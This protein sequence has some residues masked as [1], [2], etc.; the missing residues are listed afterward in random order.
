MSQPID[1]LECSQDN[2]YFS[3]IVKSNS[4]LFNS[5]LIIFI[6]CIGVFKVIDEYSHRE[7]NNSIVHGVAAYGT[8]KALS[9]AIS[10]LKGVEFSIGVVT[11]RLG[12]VL[13][14]IN[15]VLVYTS[16]IIMTALASLGLQK[17]LLMIMASSLGN[18]LLLTSACVYFITLWVKGALNFKVKAK[19][20]FY[21]IVF[22]RFS[23]A[24]TLGVNA[25]IDKAFLDPEIDKA[26]INSQ[27]FTQE[28]GEIKDAVNEQDIA[29]VEKNQQEES[30]WDK[31]K[32]MMGDMSDS[33]INTKNSIKTLPE[34]FNN[35]IMDFM[36]L[37]ALFLLKTI[38]IPIVFLF[39]LK[40]A[41]SRL[42]ATF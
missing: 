1:T 21:F 32:N 38:I 29:G 28:I 14:P 36:N 15:E 9:T 39:F 24:V 12:E 23:L 8:V 10:G 40:S 33:V 35:Y 18:A 19:S 37:I 41:Y 22:I 30:F 17:T 3:N 34:K 27:V 5:F 31:A 26:V 13:E 4:R 7:V 2:N 25:M 11:T 20:F 6:C 16:H 42:R